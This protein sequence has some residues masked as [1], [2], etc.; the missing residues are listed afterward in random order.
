M[1]PAMMYTAGSPR[2]SPN[3]THCTLTLDRRTGRPHPYRPRCRVARVGIHTPPHVRRS[4][5]CGDTNCILCQYN[6]SRL[7]TRNVK[8]KY[9]IDDHLK[10]KCSAPLRVEL[11][12]D[13]GNCHTEGLPQGVQLE[14][15]PPAGEQ[16]ARAGAGARGCVG[17]LW[18]QWQEKGGDTA[19]RKGGRSGV[20]EGSY[21]R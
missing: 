3:L 11:V 6:P 12:D 14:V 9:L 18:G 10:A 8:Q 21:I 17:A 4:T 16:L 15:R 1:T 5:G 13:Q 19:G 2:R 20:R 7:C